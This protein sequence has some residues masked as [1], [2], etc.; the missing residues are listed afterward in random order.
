LGPVVEV[1]GKHHGKVA[2][3]EIAEVLKKYE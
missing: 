1:N 3:A 2:P